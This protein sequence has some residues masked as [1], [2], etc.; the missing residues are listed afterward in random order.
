MHSKRTR[1]S[2]LCP[3]IC[4][5]H[6]VFR[7]LL[8]IPRANP[9]THLCSIYINTTSGV[10]TNSFTKKF[11]RK[12]CLSFGGKATF[13]FSTSEIGNKSLRSGAAM[14]LFLRDHSPAKIM[15]LG[16]WSSDAFLV[17]I[18]PQVLEWVKNMFGNMIQ[19]N[20]F[21][22][23]TT[24]DIILIFDL[25]SCHRPTLLNGCSH[26]IQIPTFYLHH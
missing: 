16:R 24:F 2:V 5:A 8:T 14:S 18:R 20:S 22:D 4:L 11:L 9:N 17:Y 3:C 12:T 23:V 21:L 1:D 13:G 25:Q 10:I 15:I 26:S 6:A 19:F 7:V